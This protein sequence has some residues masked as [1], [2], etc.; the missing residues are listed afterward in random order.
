MTDEP[1]ASATPTSLRSRLVWFALLYAGGVAVVG[2][3]ALLI[4]VLALAVR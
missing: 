3:V 1:D 4:R 2:A